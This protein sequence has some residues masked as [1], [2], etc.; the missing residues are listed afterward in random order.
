MLLVVVNV[1]LSVSVG[2]SYGRGSSSRILEDM[3]EY[4]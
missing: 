4:Y 1:A 3:N 2:G